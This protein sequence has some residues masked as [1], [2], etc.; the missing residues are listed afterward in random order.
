[1]WHLRAK[2]CPLCGATLSPRRIQG[3]ERPAC[4]GCSFVLFRNPACAA[5]AV[6]LNDT[7]HVLLIKRGIEPYRG[8]WALPAGYQEVDEEPGVTACREVH[9]E[10]GLEVE[11][12]G[13]VD[14]LYFPDDPR[15]PA[16]SVVFRCRVTGGALKAGDDALEAEWFDLD[17]LPENLAFDNRERILDKLPRD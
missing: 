17:D 9:E 2:F 8:S 7:G 5:A 4:T 16:T 13:L 10:T 15:K 1:V 3:R 6:V 14:V 11:V 12:I